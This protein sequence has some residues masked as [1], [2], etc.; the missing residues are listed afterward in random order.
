M[1]KKREAEPKRGTSEAAADGQNNDK[2]PG[3]ATTTSSRR[4]LIQALAASGVIVSAKLIPEKWGKPVV[5]AVALPA[6][7]QTT[8]PDSCTLGADVPRVTLTEPAS[9]YDGIVDSAR[10]ALEDLVDVAW[11]GADQ[12]EDT[13][14]CNLFTGCF[15]IQF[16]C[17]SNRGRLFARVFDIGDDTGSDEL[18]APDC[19]EISA[20]FESGVEGEIGGA[21]FV[22]TIISRD[23]ATL[24][25]LSCEGFGFENIPLD[26]NFNCGPCPNPFEDFEGDLDDTQDD[27]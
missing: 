3:A 24:Q 19:E 16:E 7:A 13:S 10:E 1:T 8:E 27:S 20:P 22:V 9:I 18:T 2:A 14:I 5:D 26:R 25:I 21:I 17:S 4:K 11:A 12:S 6:H 23:E 15:W